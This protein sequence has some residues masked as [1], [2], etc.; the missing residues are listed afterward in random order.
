MY[1]R[2]LATTLLVAAS[3]PSAIFAATPDTSPIKEVR[4]SSGGLA[5]VLR[6]A[7][8]NQDGVVR[9]EVPLEQ[10]DDILKTLVLNNDSAVIADLSLVGPQPLSETFKGL[11]VTAES[12]ASVPALLNAIQGAMVTVTSQ[13]KTVQ[14]QVLGVEPRTAADGAEAYLLSVLS[15]AG[16]IAT[17]ELAPDAMVTVDD[18]RIRDKLVQ[19]ASAIARAKNDRSRAIQIKVKGNGAQRVDLSYVVAAPIWKTAY[20]VVAGEDGKARL[21]A[22]AVL[23]NAS[24][25][26]WRNVKI[27]LSS[28][29]P[30]TLSQ[31]LHQWYWRDR[32]D[33]PVN[34]AA[35]AVPEADTG[36]L[37]KRAQA[38]RA[39]SY[40][41]AAR[42]QAPRPAPVAVAAEA[43]PDRILTQHYGGG[44]I[45]RDSQSTATES[46]VS[47]T[48]ELPGTYDVANGDTLSI[49]IL[50]AEIPASMVSLY[51]AG[52]QERH[53]VAALMLTNDTGVSLPAG[54]LTIYDARSGY[55]GDAQLAGLPGADTRLASFA[56][57]RKV[58]VTEDRKPVDEITEV[59]VVDGMLRL[60]QKARYVTDYTVA[61]AMD[62]P[63]TVIIEHPV[64]SGWTFSSPASDGKTATHHRLK[65]T[66]DKGASQTVQAVEEQLRRDTIAIADTEP[67]AL[68]AWSA[69]S[70]DR[71]LSAKLVE[72][73]EARQ[74]QMAAQRALDQ[75]EDA[76]ERL[77][78]EQA[79]IRENL[80]AVPAS[81]DLSSRYLTQLE[82][83][84]NELRALAGKRETL[85]GE[86]HQLEGKV[87]G[88]LRTF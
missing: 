36:N 33:L 57:D 12:L 34:T 9:L 41:A 62:A 7:V 51:R 84:E 19:A 22:W 28:A 24:G 32:M 38:Q 11:P 54:I 55:A 66:V 1:A 30:V 87:R 5:E 17:L 14:G 20:K 42:M 82:A 40:A 29:E 63:R 50:D 85:E 10:V 64:R 75:W 18:E 76:R 83:T 59:K 68:L 8:V 31:R 88:I 80:R 53:P 3:A 27:I 79:R 60:T 48:F 78:S 71:V 35:N 23:E 45:D 13:G 15:G 67:E 44:A 2:F 6:A 69:S 16:T 25:E 56:I 49:P 86:L 46:D 26:D 74:K 72:L 58:T 81:S 52:G 77:V 4:L 21:Q 37:T 70:T 61:G 39:A 73:S 65:V 47:A 43:A